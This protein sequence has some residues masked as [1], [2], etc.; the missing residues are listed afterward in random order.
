MPLISVIVPVYKT[1]L[2]IRQCLDS[3]NNQ[4]FKDYEVIIVDDGSPDNCPTIC[5]EYA[6]KYSNI[7]VVHKSNGGLVS[8]RKAGVLSSSGQYILAV[9]S[10]DF[11]EADYLMGFAEAIKRNKADII[12]EGFYSYNGEKNVKFSQPVECGFY[13]KKELK[14]K[15]YNRMLYEEP[16]YTFGIFPSVWTKCIRRELVIKNQINIPENIT[17]GEDAA[18]VY[19]CILDASSLEV[20][21]NNGYMYRYNN[22]SISHS[23]D[24]KMA[25]RCILLIE[26][27]YKI[28]ETKNWEAENQLYAYAIM[29]QGLV[30]RNEMSN[31]KK[32]YR[33]L[34][35][36]TKNPYIQ[37]IWKIKFKSRLPL[38]KRLELFALSRRFVWILSLKNVFRIFN[39][40]Y[41]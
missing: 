37:K 25:L 17:M 35:L 28:L 11:I 7:K 34:K 15:I 41:V 32:G 38:V 8:A 29:I 4:T 1:E 3:I 26:H 5:D 19:A 39:R 40:N 20:I 2:Y 21:S 23:Y 33:N 16:Y 18:L 12:S 24:E 6:A 9:D 27:M 36:W 10:D 30:V 22:N 13:D 14:N 31:L